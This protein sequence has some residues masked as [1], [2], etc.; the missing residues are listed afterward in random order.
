MIPFKDMDRMLSFGAKRAQ[1]R[2]D[3][4]AQGRVH[5]SDPGRTRLPPEASITL[6]A[7]R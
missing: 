4:R 3:R 5:F 6:A 1:R 7:E 2:A